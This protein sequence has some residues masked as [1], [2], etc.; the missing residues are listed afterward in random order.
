MK[1]RLLNL[2]IEKFRG[3]K[4]LELNELNDINIILGDNNSGKTS[5]LEAINLLKSDNI[6][7]LFSMLKNR[8]LSYDINNFI[9]Y[10]PIHENNIK[11][12]ANL[13][14]GK[15]NLDI[16]YEEKSVV[17]DKET[18]VAGLNE[19]LKA[20]YSRLIDM[21]Q[22]HGKEDKKIICKIKY[23]DVEKE[24]DFLNFDLKYGR[25]SENY[26]DDIVKIITETPFDH[27][28][29][30]LSIMPDILSSD[31]YSKMYIEVLRLFDSS[32]E[33]VMIIN[34]KN[35]PFIFDVYVKK[36]N[37]DPMPLSIFGDGLK[38]VALLGSF[39]VKSRDGILLIDEIETSLHHK[40]YSDVFAFI[41]R[42]ARAFN[43]QVFI[44]THND[45]T[46]KEFLKINE[47]YKDNKNDIV[48]IYTIRN[49]KEKTYARLLK[50][51]EAYEYI[52]LNGNEGRL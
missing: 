40:Y 17:F 47:K 15:T 52:V 35:Y 37:E 22:Q 14:K 43:V 13:L 51:S 23:N 18:Y 38:K 21:S 46:I 25:I 30:T 8:N 26:S 11:M 33:N 3:I 48:N 41:V 28:K 31:S 20:A 29:N 10:F 16:S 50:G 39:L 9:Y 36:E 34:N 6:F 7:N 19:E 27:F 4:N 5:I 49:K 24:Y 45:E 44:T 2:K 32:I 42:I 1:D 12:H